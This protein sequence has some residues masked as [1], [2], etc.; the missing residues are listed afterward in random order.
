LSC[1]IVCLEGSCYSICCS[2]VLILAVVVGLLA[3]ATVDYGMVH[4]ETSLQFFARKEAKTWESVTAGSVSVGKA[5]TNLTV[6]DDRS[7]VKCIV[8]PQICNAVAA[9]GYLKFH[10]AASR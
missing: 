1:F 10:L 3:D 4:W 6:A 5:S 8:Q 7:P 2:R 9:I